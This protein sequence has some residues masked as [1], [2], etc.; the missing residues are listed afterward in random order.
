MGQRVW[1][2]IC[3]N[4]SDLTGSSTATY[5]PFRMNDNIILKGLRHWIIFYN[6]PSVNSLKCSIYADDFSSGVH[7]PSSLIAESSTIWTK[8]DIITLDNGFFEIYYE[9]DDIPLQGSTWYHVVFNATTYAPTASSFVAVR[10]AYPDPVYA[11]GLT[12]NPTKLDT[13]PYA[14]Y[15][16]GAEF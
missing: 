11:T 3:Y 4:A 5:Q 1:G 7:T 12:V 8:S 14:L 13:M 6:N 9:F 10:L 15:F 2:R 16:I